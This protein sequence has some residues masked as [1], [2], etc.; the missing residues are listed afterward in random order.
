MSKD[1]TPPKYQRDVHIFT[2][3]PV[4]LDTMR[5]DAHSAQKDRVCSCSSSKMQWWPQLSQK[6]DVH[7]LQKVLART[8]VFLTGSNMVALLFVG[9]LC[10]EECAGKGGG[11]LWLA[12]TIPNS[13]Y[14]LS[15]TVQFSS[16]FPSGLGPDLNHQYSCCD[17]V[18]P[19][20]VAKFTRFPLN[21]GRLIV[22]IR[23]WERRPLVWHTIAF[24]IFCSG[25][26]ERQ[27]FFCVNCFQSMEIFV[28]IL[29]KSIWFVPQ[30][31][32][33]PFHHSREI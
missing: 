22:P 16:S 29:T 27:N 33:F 24:L 23:H 5:T 14:F 26:W 15:I 9:W 20:T 25:S 31:A 2:S 7:I 6:A 18:P 3:C 21:I 4:T 13:F 11:S 19:Q 12:Q 32:I 30:K 28:D 8:V 1:I 17:S 10:T